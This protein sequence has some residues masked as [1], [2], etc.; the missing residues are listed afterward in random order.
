MARKRRWK[1]IIRGKAGIERVI[2][3]EGL[4]CDEGW[5]DAGDDTH[6]RVDHDN[7]ECACGH[8]LYQR[9]WR[10][11]GLAKTRLSTVGRM[12]KATLDWHWK[13]CALRFNNCHQNRYAIVWKGGRDHLLFSL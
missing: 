8:R 13:E 3:T 11:L 9:D 1:A 12:S 4:A 7:T 2:D 10:V 5:G 6:C